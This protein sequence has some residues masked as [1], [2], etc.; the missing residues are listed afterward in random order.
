ML[1]CDAIISGDIQKQMY[2]YMKPE[3]NA[4]ALIRESISF[5]ILEISSLYQYEE[6]ESFY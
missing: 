4:L 6:T 1:I 2:G 3:L 5:G